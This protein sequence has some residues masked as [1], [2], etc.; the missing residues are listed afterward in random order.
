MRIPLKKINYLQL[1]KI[2]KQKKKSHY[3]LKCGTKGQVDEFVRG[4]ILYPLLIV[5]A[6]LKI[7]KL[8]IYLK[9]QNAVN[10]IC[11]CSHVEN[12]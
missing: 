10:F 6:K 11:V 9:N 8:V 1:C 2:T 5:W 4:A 7:L 3:N 12:M